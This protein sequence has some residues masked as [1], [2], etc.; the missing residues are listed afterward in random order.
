M[1][2]TDNDQKIDWPV[3]LFIFVALP[4]AFTLGGVW[5]G[6]GVLIFGVVVL[7]WSKRHDG[8]FPTNKK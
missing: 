6:I 2:N 4:A 3:M 8:P 5:F 1:P 7:G